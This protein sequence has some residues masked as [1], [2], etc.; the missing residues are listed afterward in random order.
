MSLRILYTVHGY[1]P[2]YRLGG[3]IISVSAVAERLVRRGHQVVVFTSDSNADQDLDVPLNQPVDVDGV[4]VW[5]FSRKDF[6]QRL[7]FFLPYFAKSI[8]FMYNARI[9]GHLERLLPGMDLVHAHNPFIYPT[10]AA[11]RAAQRIGKPLF[12]NQRGVFDP[13]RLKFRSVKKRLYI[14]LVARPL[15][16]KATTLIA[17]TKSEV[18]SYRDLG[19]KN[20]CR[21]VPNGI[22]VSVYRQHPGPTV[23]ALFKIPPQAQVILFMGRVHPIKGADRLLEAFLLIHARLPRAV[24]VLAGPDEWGCEAK[25]REAVRQAGLQER[26]IFPGMVSGEAKCDL[27]ARAD[28]FCLPSDAEGFSMAV[29]EALASSTPVL[30]SPGCH[31]PEVEAAGAGL[32]VPPTPE[33]L[34]RTLVELLGQSE[35]LKTMGASGVEFVSRNYSWDH[36]TDQL[37]DVYLEGIQRH[38]KFYG[39]QA[40]SI[41]S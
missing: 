40:A 18:Q 12:F 27:L 20:T 15:L 7:F 41:S 10:Y 9:P 11:A 4:E 34:A 5:Y 29:L 3:P 8:G 33:A 31:F 14:N 16:Q 32:V 30:L 38:E 2:A 1:K 28:L 22:D 35:R 21:I 13:E 6:T 24:L 25:F 36:I 23:E 26:V 37:L 19:L 17:L 39:K